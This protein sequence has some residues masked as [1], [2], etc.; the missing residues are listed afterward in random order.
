[1]CKV[2]FAWLGRMDQELAAEGSAADGPIVSALGW[3]GF[4]EL[5]LLSDWGPEPTEGYVGWLRRYSTSALEVIPVDLPGGPTDFGQIYESAVRAV[6]AL[7]RARPEAELTFHLSPGTPAMAAVWIILA[8]TRYSAQLIESSK[9]RGVRRASVPFN[10]SAEYIPDLLASSDLKLRDIALGAP[11]GAAEF[12]DILYRCERMGRLVER[13]TRTAMRSVPVLIE[14]E[15]G[16]G[17]EL[18]ARAIHRAGPRRARPFVAVNCGALPSE[19][20]ESALFGHVKGAFTGADRDRAGFFEQASEG[21]LFLD[22]LGELPLDAQVKLLRALQEGE[23]R[24]V[25]GDRLIKVTPRVIAATNRRL[26][27]EVA[28][29]RF[30]EDLYYRLAVAVLRIPPLRDRGDDVVMLVDRL[31]AKAEEDSKEDPNYQHKR[32]SEAARRRLVAHTWPGNVRELENTLVRIAVWSRGGDIGEDEVLEALTPSSARTATILDR[33][34]G[35]DLSLRD[36]QAEVAR[37]YLSRAMAQAEGKKTVAAR[38]LGFANYQTLGN[39]LK[40]YPADS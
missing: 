25:G 1:M 3:G 24:R 36:L 6:D 32:L 30:R 8:K 35:G 17:K 39:W 7:R 38:L 2:L 34:L 13:A 23:L 20:V 31:W 14:G 4:D 27:E 16:T 5:R 11:P 15:S 10:L 18:L 33:P 37:H 21:T 29:G 22:E 28:A 9:Q 19:L 26:L 12:G 40:R